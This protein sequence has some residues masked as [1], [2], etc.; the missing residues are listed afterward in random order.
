[1]PH[2]RVLIPDEA[3]RNS[4]S[5]EEVDDEEEEEEDDWDDLVVDDDHH[6]QRH[7]QLDGA[8]T[9]DGDDYSV[10]QHLQYHT[11]NT[12][13][14]N[15]MGGGGGYGMENPFFDFVGGGGGTNGGGGY[16]RGGGGGSASQRESLLEYLETTVNKSILA[17]PCRNGLPTVS[18]TG[19][20][21]DALH[22]SVGK[23]SVGL[24]EGVM[25]STSPLR[26]YLMGEETRTLESAN[27]HL[28]G[29]F[30]WIDSGTGTL[31]TVLTQAN[32][33]AE[34]N[35]RVLLNSEIQLI[36]RDDVFFVERLLSRCEEGPLSES[37][38]YSLEVVIKWMRA[39]CSSAI[40]GDQADLEPSGNGS[41]RLEET[42]FRSQTNQDNVFS[43]SS[44]KSGSSG[45]FNSGKRTFLGKSSLNAVNA[46]DCNLTDQLNSAHSEH[47]EV[48][49]AR[50][51]MILSEQ[52]RHGS[53]QI[54]DLARLLSAELDRPEPVGPCDAH[55]CEKC[56][57]PLSNSSSSGDGVNCGPN[58]PFGP[59]IQQTPLRS[60]INVKNVS[61]E[62]DTARLDSAPSS[63]SSGCPNCNCDSNPSVEL[64]ASSL[65]RLLSNHVNALRLQVHL[66]D[67]KIHLLRSAEAE[68]GDAKNHHN[69]TQA[70]DSVYVDFNNLTAISSETMRSSGYL[71]LLNALQATFDELA[72]VINH[73]MRLLH[74]F[75]PSHALSP[76]FLPS[77]MSVE[78]NVFESDP[79]APVALSTQCFGVSSDQ[80]KA[81]R[82]R[83]GLDAA[84]S[85]ADL[86]D[87]LES[88]SFTQFHSEQLLRVVVDLQA[89][90][91]TA[92]LLLVC[93]MSPV[94]LQQK[95]VSLPA[96]PINDFSNSDRSSVKLHSTR[97]SPHIS[98][99]SSYLPHLGSSRKKAPPPPLSSSGSSSIRSEGYPRD[100]TDTIGEDSRPPVYDV[101]F[102]SAVGLMFIRLMTLIPSPSIV[103]ARLSFAAYSYLRKLKTDSLPWQKDG[104]FMLIDS[105]ELLVRNINST[106][107]LT[108]D[109]VE[110]AVLQSFA[111]AF[112]SLDEERTL[113]LLLYEA[114]VDI[115][116]TQ[117]PIVKQSSEASR[118]R[119]HHRRGS[120]FHKSVFHLNSGRKDG[121]HS[122]SRDKECHVDDV[123]DGLNELASTDPS[124]VK[125]ASTQQ[126][127]SL[128]DIFKHAP[129]SL[130][131]GRS[132]FESLRQKS[133]GTGRRI[134]PQPAETPPPHPAHSLK[135]YGSARF[136]SETIASSTPLGTPASCSSSVADEATSFKS[137][138]A[139]PLLH[140]ES[141]FARFIPNRAKN[142]SLSYSL[143]FELFT[144]SHEIFSHLAQSMV[145]TSPTA[146]LGLY[147]MCAIVLAHLN[148]KVELHEHHRNAAILAVKLERHEA[149]VMH[150]GYVLSNL[151]R[152]QQLGGG[153]GE[154]DLSEL[155][156][157]TELVAGE[158][159]DNAQHELAIKTLFNTLH[160]V[161]S[162][163]E[164]G[165][166][167][168]LSGPTDSGDK[169]HYS[170]LSTAA[171]ANKRIG[172]AGHHRNETWSGEYVNRDRLVYTQTE[173]ER[174]VYPSMMK[175]GATYLEMGRSAK[176]ADTFQVL[177]LVL[178][179]RVDCIANDEK[180]VAV[181]S[182][183]AECYLAMDDFDGAHRVLR[184][185]K[186]VRKSKIDQVV[187]PLG[188][189]TPTIASTV[190]TKNVVG[191][192]LPS[193]LL[194]SPG[195]PVGPN[196]ADRSFLTK[197]RPSPRS[198]VG[199]PN[200]RFFAENNTKASEPIMKREVRIAGQKPLSVAVP[201]VAT[202]FKYHLNSK[203]CCLP[204]HCVTTYNT[205]LGD[206][207]ARVY[208]KNKQFVQALKSL[209]PTIIGVELIVGGKGARES[210]SNKEGLLELG[211]LYYLRG[212]IQLEAS[213]SCAAIKYPFDVGSVQLFA[214][215]Q[216]ISSD[217]RRAKSVTTTKKQFSRLP[218]AVVPG[219]QQSSRRNHNASFSNLSDKELLRTDSVHSSADASQSRNSTGRS[220]RYTAGM[221]NLLTC[222]RTV[223]YNNPSDLLWDAMR[224]FRRAWDLFHAAGD[225]VS[226]AK[227]ANYIATCHLTPTFTP[228]VFFNTSLEKASNLSTMVPEN[229]NDLSGTDWK[230]LL[231]SAVTAGKRNMK[232][233]NR[234]SSQRL[235]RPVSQ[236]KGQTQSIKL[237]VVDGGE[238]AFN[239]T[240]PI[241][242]RV[243]LPAGGE[244]DASLKLRPLSGKSSGSSV[245]L[246][247]GPALFPEHTPDSPWVA[248]SNET[249]LK[250]RPLST[251]SS[252]SVLFRDLRD[253][254]SGDAS[255]PM[256][257]ARSVSNSSVIFS[258]MRSTDS[259]DDPQQPFDARSPAAP[260]P[261]LQMVGRSNSSGVSSNNNTTTNNDFRSNVGNGYRHNESL[262]SINEMVDS[263][264]GQ[265]H[266]LHSSSSGTTVNTGPITTTLGKNGSV[267]SR[268]ASLEEVQRVM[269]F[270]LEIS[271]ESCL[272]LVIIEA[273]VNLA[274]LYVL[275]ENRQDGLA[276]WWEAR[277]LFLH[278]YCDG[279]LIPVLRVASLHFMQ[280]LASVCSRMVRFLWTC[281]RVVVNQNLFLLDTH[282]IITNEVARVAKRM[283]VLAQQTA[284][285]LDLVLHR[286]A[287]VPT[288]RLPRSRL[289]AR[290]Q[291]KEGGRSATDSKSTGS[292]QK[293]IRSF[294]RTASTDTMD[295]DAAQTVLA[296]V[297]VEMFF[298]RH[299][300][301]AQ[302]SNRDFFGVIMRDAVADKLYDFSWRQY[303]DY[304]F[305]SSSSSSLSVNP[306]PSVKI[307]TAPSS[308]DAHLPPPPV[309]PQLSSSTL[310]VDGEQVSA[311]TS[312]SPSPSVGIGGG[313]RRSASS[314]SP[315]LAKQLLGWK[316]KR[317]PVMRN[318][319]VSTTNFSLQPVSSSPLTSAVASCLS[320]RKYEAVPDA[321]RKYV[322]V[323]GDLMADEDKGEESSGCDETPD[324]RDDFDDDTADEATVPRPH[325]LSAM[326]TGGLKNIANVSIVILRP[327][328]EDSASSVGGGLTDDYQSTTSTGTS[329]YK[330]DRFGSGNPDRG[331]THSI[332]QQQQPLDP[333]ADFTWMDDSFSSYYSEALLSPVPLAT[334]NRVGCDPLLPEAIDGLSEDSRH[335]L[336]STD[337]LASGSTEARNVFAELEA[338]SEGVM[339]QRVWRCYLMM[340]NAQR[341]YQ[342]RKY[343]MD[344]L[345]HSTRS[346]LRNLSLFM[347]RLRAFSRQYK[348]KITIYDDL[349][350]TVG[351]GCES[352]EQLDMATNLR[353][354]I[355]AAGRLSGGDLLPSSAEAFGPSRDSV[356]R[357]AVSLFHRLPHIAYAIHIDSLLMLYRPHD[358]AQSIQL[359]G[360]AGY[361]LYSTVEKPV[362]PVAPPSTRR[363]Q[364]KSPRKSHRRG[365][366]AVLLTGTP[367]VNSFSLPNAP[368]QPSNLPSIASFMLPYVSS[369]GDDTPPPTGRSLSVEVTQRHSPLGG[370][371]SVSEEVSLALEGSSHLWKD[372]GTPTAASG[373]VGK[374][375]RPPL[376][377]GR[378]PF[379]RSLSNSAAS[380]VDLSVEASPAAT[381]KQSVARKISSGGRSMGDDSLAC[382]SSSGSSENLHGGA[383]RHRGGKPGEE[384]GLSVKAISDLRATAAAS[385]SGGAHKSLTHKID[386]L[387]S[388]LSGSSF[389]RMSSMESVFQSAS[390]ANNKKPGYDS[391]SSSGSDLIGPPPPIVPAPPLATFESTLEVSLS[392]QD[393]QLLFDLSVQDS[394][395]LC[396][397][398][399]QTRQTQFDKMAEGVLVASL[400]F[401]QSSSVGSSGHIHE[402]IDRSEGTFAAQT[403]REFG[404]RVTSPLTASG[405]SSIFG[406]AASWQRRPG[407]GNSA[408]L[409]S[410]STATGGSF[411][412]GI[413]GLSRGSSS[414]D[415][416]T[417]LVPQHSNRAVGGIF[418]MFQQSTFDLMGSAHGA[419]D[420]A[421]HQ[422]SFCDSPEQTNRVARPPMQPI[423]LTLLCSRGL[424]G[425]PWEILLPDSR[426]VRGTSIL[427]LCTQSFSRRD[428]RSIATQQ[429]SVEGPSVS[430]H[431][432][433][434]HSS[435]TPTA[436]EVLGRP[437]LATPKGSLRTSRFLRAESTQTTSA[438]PPQRKSM[439]GH[440]GPGWNQ[441]PVFVV[442][443]SVEAR[444]LTM[445]TD[446]VVKAEL[447]R[448]ARSSLSTLSLL[449]HKSD[450][451]LRSLSQ[452]KSFFGAQTASVDHEMSGLSHMTYPVTS[453]LVLSTL[454]HRAFPSTGPQHSASNH[455]DLT[456]VE[457]YPE[458]GPLGLAQYLQSM[459][460]KL[461]SLDDCGPSDGDASCSSFPVLLLSYSD[462]LEACDAIQYLATR[463][464]D[465][466]FIF[467]PQFVIESLAVEIKIALN[468][469]CRPNIAAA[470]SRLQPQLKRPASSS[471]LRGLKSVPSFLRSSSSTG[472]D[473]QFARDGLATA[474]EDELGESASPRIV[475]G[476]TD[477]DSPG[478]SASR[479]DTHSHS[480]SLRRSLSSF[481]LSGLGSSG[482]TSGN[483]DSAN[484]RSNS[485]SSSGSHSR[486]FTDALLGRVPSL[487]PMT[488]SNSSSFYSSSGSTVD[489]HL[490]TVD[491]GEESDSS[492]QSVT[493]AAAALGK[494]SSPAPRHRGHPPH[495]VA[496]GTARSPN[497]SVHKGA[498][499]SIRA[500]DRTWVY[501]ALLAVVHQAQQEHAV[502]I[503]VFI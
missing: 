39:S 95:P 111:E 482:S 141:F 423:P 143:R 16:D 494:V 379:D 278:L 331:I 296:P 61:I 272:P 284:R 364:S 493:A 436:A 132:L 106:G 413:S 495:P 247:R 204:K 64:T 309:S 332:E 104:S 21:R 338:R 273:Y 112:G 65:Y 430:H 283:G 456:V 219:R 263:E 257:S 71:V 383:G 395:Q 414:G 76:D 428:L 346:T 457:L 215:I 18:S 409:S 130:N 316:D 393:V 323:R 373:R 276:Y 6:Q 199:T 108:A 375:S 67:I 145:D 200:Q 146:A 421:E 15:M 317:A 466:V 390:S 103:R 241:S 326:A 189:S 325:A 27:Q 158:Y 227:S 37:C 19:V 81:V 300:F 211:R 92:G 201:N 264:G 366:L 308:K 72:F 216:L 206:L 89:M 235:S 78:A 198:Q 42:P 100:R 193:P 153:G 426:V 137:S 265:K 286:F 402:L 304:H 90:C 318:P 147:K 429:L 177:L 182:W 136:N 446:L 203:E 415:T 384:E 194:V 378:F 399:K 175:I 397:G 472:A 301:G 502:P 240:P 26:T 289:S 225:E 127:S 351:V 133:S 231:Q 348:G 297:A 36:Q 155:M 454:K 464:H 43:T 329:S 223:T 226:A 192:A 212:K 437:P 405:T 377:S 173:F 10:D 32:C 80:S 275:Q 160:H 214:A 31:K 270:A 252:S 307:S 191:I 217:V 25:A 68:R 392:P 382:S 82:R 458:G 418:S 433:G 221:N 176:A 119:Q 238:Q 439:K 3:S 161:N 256:L 164:L 356:A 254:R 362:V 185:I 116:P 287:D 237:D 159:C 462:L 499:D 259:N 86:V 174:A 391:K 305:P 372:I 353:T 261:P 14:A 233:L 128:R 411:Q 483:L 477:L 251:R 479:S 282:L 394:S 299:G 5:E 97:L 293:R 452:Y 13:F 142:T 280:K 355:G 124:E 218:V 110:R 138:P 170:F 70:A 209:T 58:D 449:Q 202:T 22:S 471:F 260:P 179:D 121:T 453:P 134:V 448:K 154:T 79:E 266:K 17:E 339:I 398:G 341:N 126:Q 501:H 498:R 249:S 2:A 56:H 461:A 314:G 262:A 420:H 422:Q 234:A 69:T 166:S 84:R 340:R 183:V 135:G 239:L 51:G 222:K 41:V 322:V 57:L 279:A 365:E 33:S 52:S 497:S 4:H 246:R 7:H 125:V 181:L 306:S 243:A 455:L 435:S 460:S 48:T 172:V 481:S 463:R 489:N 208:F 492:Q 197:D 408:S 434:G 38:L 210:V 62:I 450:A 99:L 480:F 230:E 368:Q 74:Q 310:S 87:E 20:K 114:A 370:I 363:S 473:E 168:P 40:N 184:A 315:S 490:N 186:E 295:L 46:T 419:T 500:K 291:Q 303:V 302:L 334:P 178:A 288:L 349:V 376:A 431:R 245:S 406:R 321:L 157:V 503:A 94:S 34:C 343:S 327:N 267:V 465:A 478:S 271:L 425:V 162:K 358:G 12:S 105:S 484:K 77:V 75:L 281:D 29:L 11:T 485:R 63:S 371:R 354:Y 59:Q 163:K 123:V 416:D 385:G 369:S 220:A 388:M 319:A 381:T 292:T 412:Q 441:K 35:A 93:G 451:M 188:V 236:H 167:I 131:L 359:F 361:L 113:Q 47:F 328:G 290:Q 169:K 152:D 360:G 352:D 207:I 23:P 367:R 347:Y 171:A 335:L 148:R 311:A 486:S 140:K 228:T 55:L 404:E 285:S 9:D 438:A 440:L 45:V 49:I 443:A 242:N 195:T 8:L 294:L 122:S 298:C 337:S 470:G 144:L 442:N 336:A 98:R 54:R 255:A 101:A 244:E 213:K 324:A 380:P 66:L 248:N 120:S 196:A 73:W 30:G 83:L 165:A 150:G 410:I 102:E 1:M 88:D 118:K 487:P 488:T 91:A 444:L 475:D 187:T 24:A 107:N 85:S 156:Y 320:R 432:G 403:D 269:Q 387:M 357:R 115:L 396:A 400:T 467:A 190:N 129:L 389:S 345:R 374:D 139:K 274:E 459:E 96:A 28:K 50:C 424:Q 491:G 313:H 205:D 330:M 342:S 151:L 333:Y 447:Q 476:G 53:S 180:K 407:R 232:A 417:T 253:A 445:R 250:H 344:M 468:R 401:L 312:R 469:W 277:E 350:S 386:S 427:S 496:P 258:N 224:W 268:F 149:A 117:Q 60:R 229:V 474:V 44:I 109:M